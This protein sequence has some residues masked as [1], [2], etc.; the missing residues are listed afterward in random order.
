MKD[1]VSV[2][3][4]AR[5]G[6]APKYGVLAEKLR[7]KILRGT[8]T[9]GMRL[10]TLQELAAE[11]GVARLTAREAVQVLVQEGLLD[12][13]QGSGTF[14]ASG[15]PPRKTVQVQTTLRALSDMY[16]RH[17]PEIRT[18]DEAA[19]PLPP[20]VGGG[21]ADFVRLRRV[22]SEAGVAYCVITIYVEARLFS[23]AAQRFRRDAAIP[24]L[25]SLA[26][27]RIA[28]AHQTLTVGT[29]DAEVAA[30]LSIAESAP[31]AYVERTFEGPDGHVVYFAEVIYRGGA[32]RLEIELTV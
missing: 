1:L 5:T 12:S 26:D 9:P 16:I 6:A 22:H 20:H 10:P 19:A 11:A 8:F 4:T 21:D 31:V 28:R 18:L 14:V 15:L 29:A 25:L 17:P 7:Q 30:L 2:N 23:Q 32:V 13:R 3:K 27:C 24:V